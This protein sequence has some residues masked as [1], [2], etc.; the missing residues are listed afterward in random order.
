MSGSLPVLVWE[1]NILEIHRLH[2]ELKL[3][4]RSGE[5]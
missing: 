3:Q 5:S 4:W 2:L 1:L